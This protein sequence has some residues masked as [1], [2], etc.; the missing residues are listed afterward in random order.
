MIDQLE[1]GVAH[2]VVDRLGA[3]D[4]HQVETTPLRQFG[5]FIGRVHRI[6]AADVE[7]IAHLV[8]LEDL[9]DTLDILDL[10]LLEL[11]AAG[12]DAP[13]RRRH[14]EQGDFLRRLR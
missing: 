9:H 8:S 10:L 4:H 6:V 3:A 13:S 2:V 14:P 11:V 7:E 12:S 5:N 1:F